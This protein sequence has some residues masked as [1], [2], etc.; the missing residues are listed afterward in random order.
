MSM[1]TYDHSRNE[2]VN[3]G[4]DDEPG[5]LFA[6]VTT[7]ELLE[8]GSRLDDEIE[9]RTAESIAPLKAQ[10]DAIKSA[11]RDRALAASTTLN[12][13]A[14]RVEYVKAGERVTWDDAGVLVVAARLA[15]VSPELCAQLLSY[16]R[17][18]DV[19]PTARV[20]FAVKG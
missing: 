6:N 19:E 8:R 5:V 15:E 10:L 20:R 12:G 1:A 14:G 9:A 3:D 16:R 11:L 13:Q 2:R 4:P 17:V 7:E 18:S